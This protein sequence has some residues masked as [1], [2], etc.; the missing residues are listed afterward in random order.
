MKRT[1]I[2][3]LPESSHDAACD[4][5]WNAVTAV[6]KRLGKIEGAYVISTSKFEEINQ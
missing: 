6:A 2:I 5:M 4:A 1:V 3:H